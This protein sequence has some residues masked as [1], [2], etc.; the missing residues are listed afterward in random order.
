MAFLRR[1]P[2][3]EKAALKKAAL[4]PVER[5]ADL[6]RLRVGGLR[7]DALTCAFLQVECACGHVGEVPVAPLQQ[8]YGRAS[9]VRDALGAIRCSRCGEQTIR[10]VYAHR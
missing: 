3:K 9:R 1:R 7:L 4:P 8:R 6:P 10:R 5:A 2:G